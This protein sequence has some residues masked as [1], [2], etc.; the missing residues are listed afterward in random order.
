MI[1]FRELSFKNFLSTGTHPTTIQLDKTKTTLVHGVNGSGKSTILDAL[2][3]VLFNK[4]FRKINLPQLINSSNKKELLTEVKFS[5]GK[6][7]F[8]VIRGQ[9]PK[10][11]Q[12]YRDGEP[13][14]SKASDKDNQVYLEQNILKMNYKTFS[15]V[16]ILGSANYV[17]FMALNGTGRKECVEDFLDIRVFSVML[18]LAKSRLGDLRAS[19]NQ[20]K[21]DLSNLDY[22]MDLQ[23][24]RVEEIKSKSE[25]DIY[26]LTQSI[27]N[28]QD[29]GKNI[30]KEVDDLRTHKDEVNQQITELLTTD[31]ESK[32]N[33]FNN[34]NI[35]IKQKIKTIDTNISFY[36]NNDHCHSCGQSIEQ[37]VK[38]VNISKYETEKIKL[39][40]ATHQADTMIEK[41]TLKLNDIRDKRDYVQGIDNEIYKRETE[42]KSIRNSIQENQTKIESIQSDTSSLTRE[43]DRLKEFV[44]D[45]SSLQQQYDNS[46]NEIREN[47]IVV[48][49]LKDS[50]IKTQIVRKYLPVMN[51]FIR[52]YLSE[53]ELDIHFTLDEEFNERVS[54][55]MYQD[56]SY[57]SFSEGQ[58]SRIDLAL[59]LTW[60][61]LGK[62]KNSV[63]T[64][65]LILD[66]VFSS[67][68]DEVGK[69]LLLQILRWGL[70]SN[71][72]IIIVDHT[73][74]S[75][76]KDKFDRS[77]EVT[78]TKGFS[79]YIN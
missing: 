7:N 49:L 40:E 78:K 76:F 23:R 17:P 33:K 12:V 63:S 79:S 71:Q 35:G 53:L 59:M 32:Y 43:E 39:V 22:K 37:H 47:E 14:D 74:S 27:H 5:I 73:L 62:L 34:A 20:L 75:T 57:A 60:R 66:E 1:I 16:V 77:I 8:T 65:L 26:L 15:Q 30:T 19:S 50:G 29:T 48:N 28:L 54:S 2:T 31:P 56:F 42:I 6:N 55:P 51:K 44:I 9:K 24:E 21:G 11:F 4:P 61:E 69:E 36:Q 64:N 10:V 3:Y 18:T 25:D 38:D 52:K 45:R 72:N 13:I 58:K 46:L 41:L 70:D 67:S 68:L